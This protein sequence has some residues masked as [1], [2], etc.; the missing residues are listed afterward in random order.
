[1]QV[2]LI[3]ILRKSYDSNTNESYTIVLPVETPSGHVLDT[4]IR[5]LIVGNSVPPSM[6]RS[7]SSSHHT[8]PRCLTSLLSDSR[9]LAQKRLVTA[10][11]I[12]N[13]LMLGRSICAVLFIAAT[14]KLGFKLGFKLGDF[15]IH[16]S[17]LVFRTFLHLPSFGNL[18]LV[19]L[20]SILG[21]RRISRFLTKKRLK[22][23][24][25]LYKRNFAVA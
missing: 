3:D 24:R 16:P 22:Y 25:R 19:T 7:H 20:G 23:V 10:L 8:P 18:V 9:H 21:K 6:H 13:S 2:S 11:P 1:M 12:C 4:D 14:P 17:A 5:S 15:L